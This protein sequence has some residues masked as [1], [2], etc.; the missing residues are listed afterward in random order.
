MKSLYESIMDMD[1]TDLDYVR[2]DL[3]DMLNSKSEDEWNRRWDYLRLRLS[4]NGETAPKDQHGYLQKKQGRVYIRLYRVSYDN[5][6]KSM[7]F[8][9]DTDGYILG[10]NRRANEV[11]L[12][13]SKYIRFRD[14]HFNSKGYDEYPLYILPNDLKKSYRELIK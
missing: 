12:G 7:H 5:T 14:S 11:K 1:D 3:I 6:I 9:R 10:W 13:Q 4:T 8:G 2:G